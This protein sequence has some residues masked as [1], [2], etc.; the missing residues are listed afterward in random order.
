ML[1]FTA[2]KRLKNTGLLLLLLQLGCLW[3]SCYICQINQVNS[4]SG[5]GTVTQSSTLSF[6]T[7]TTTTVWCGMYTLCSLVAELRGW[8]LGHEEELR[9]QRELMILMQQ[10]ASSR[11]SHRKKYYATP[12]KLKAAMRAGGQ[13][14]HL[15]PGYVVSA[16]HHLWLSC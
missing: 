3:R 6:T 5:N 4:H 11:P 1:G 13:S 7:T 16:F 8:V 15:H 12:R 14:K 9:R 2:A 10:Q